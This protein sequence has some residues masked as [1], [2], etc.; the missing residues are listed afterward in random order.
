V[1]RLLMVLIVIAPWTI[2]LTLEILWHVYRKSPDRQ[3][4]LEAAPRRWSWLLLKAAGVKVVA[5]NPPKMPLERPL[6]VVANHVSWFDVLA[7]CAVTPGR[8]L[9]VAKKEVR[10]APFLGRSI[11]ECG[12]I[13]IDRSD[14]QKAL[15]ELSAL[16]GRLAEEKP[17]IIMFPEGTRSATGELQP[18][19]KGAFVL[20]MEAGADVVPTAVIG[21]R[22]IMKKHSLWI[23]AGTITVRFGDP[24]AVAGM[25]TKE[26]DQL[27]QDSRDTVA[28]LLAAPVTTSD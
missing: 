17:I 15:Q 5:E 8:Y 6:V 25:S 26:R 16:R 13:F 2:Y 21:S 3:R 18:F 23:H 11:E 19:K 12:H 9:F 7:L 10:R 28:R 20:A 4:I 24:I 14:R 22:A 1:I 27:I